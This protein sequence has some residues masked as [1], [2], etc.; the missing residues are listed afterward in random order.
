MALPGSTTSP[1]SRS[2]RGLQ[3]LLT[4]IGVVACVAGTLSAFFGSY[5]QLDHGTVV[6]SVDSELRFYAAWYIFAGAAL[7]HAAPRAEQAAFT[8]R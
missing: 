8:I 7:L 3:I 1:I 5:I 4:V 2:R 6:P